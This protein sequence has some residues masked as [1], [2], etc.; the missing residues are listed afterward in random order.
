[1]IEWLDLV[2]VCCSANRE[3]VVAVKLNLGIC[4]CVTSCK[5]TTSLVGVISPVV[6]TDNVAIGDIGLE[7][8]DPGKELDG[9]IKVE[10]DFV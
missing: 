6:G 3:A 10:F 5:S 4:E 7:L 8:N 2:K 9:V 1:V